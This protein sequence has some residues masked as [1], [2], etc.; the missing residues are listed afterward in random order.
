VALYTRGKARRSL[1][2]TV[3]FRA[4]SQ[5]TTLVGYVVLVRGISKE[6][7]GILNLL[8]AFIPVISTVASLGL[9]QTLRRYQPEYLRAGNQSAAGWLFRFVASARFGTS[10][11]VLS[12]VLLTWN[13]VAPLFKLTPYRGEFALFSLLVV[14]HFQARILQFALNSH[15]LHRFSVGSVAVLTVVKLVAYSLLAWQGSLT[16]VNAILADT[17]AYVASY[18]LLTVVYRVR[19]RPRPAVNRYRPPPEERHRLFRYGFFN[20][21]NDAGTAVLSVK[22]DNFFIAALIDPI[23]VGIYSFYTRLSQMAGHLL[24]VRLFENVVQPLF[25]S[26]PQAEASKRVPNYFSLL[27]DTNLL[28]QLPVLAYAIGYHAELVQVVFGGKF[29]EQSWLL[30]VIVGFGTINVIAIPVTLVAQY[31]EKAS[32]ILLSKI[33]GVYNVIAL[34][35][36]LPIAGLLGATLASGSAQ[37]FKN[38]FIWWHV[39]RDARWLRGTRVA[40]A[41]LV[42]WGSAIASCYMLK[43]TTSLPAVTTLLFGALIC[44]IAALAH[45]RSWAISESDRKIL[46]VVLKGREARLLRILGLTRRAPGT[47]T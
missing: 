26:I 14:L 12:L 37:A 47:A 35:L 45:M 19:C 18:L 25:F 34:L 39:R 7:F 3:V 38:L 41:C 43:N 22:G 44:G 1:I 28:L 2:D 30:P 9:E 8:Y 15:M 23:S 40:A 27:I 31:E 13:W 6:D 20:N 42:I 4:V 17:C 36:L 11:V 10:V 29:I 5:I 21:F 32:I 33:F 46:G 24:P 16:L